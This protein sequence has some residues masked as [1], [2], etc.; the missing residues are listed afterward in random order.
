MTFEISRYSHKYKFLILIKRD[1]RLEH[2]VERYRR[3]K[4]NVLFACTYRRNQKV[5]PRNGHE[6]TSARW[7]D[8]R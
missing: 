1:V 2:D 7:N 5:Q 8:V 6:E 4:R 3:G